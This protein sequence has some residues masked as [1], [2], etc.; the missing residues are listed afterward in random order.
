MVKVSVILPLYNSERF[1]EDCLNSLLN[2][3]FKDYELIILDDCSTD[4]TTEILDK[5]NVKYYKNKKNLGF[6]RNLNK[7]IRM[8][9]GKY[10]M[11]TDHDMIY[12]KNYL[13]DMM[14]EKEDIMAGRCYY[15]S[16]KNLIRG[17]GITIN[18]LT[19]KTTVNGRDKFD[20][21]GNL[22]VYEIAE[23]KSA[24]GGTLMFKKE[25]YD[26]IKF[27]ES[28]NKYY[29][30]IDFCYSA[31]KQGFNMFLSKA[32]CWHKKEKKDVF[33]EQQLKEYYQDKT[34]F[35]KKHSPYYPFCLIP[36]KIKQMIQ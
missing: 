11:I 18:L 23:I 10:I 24:G 32:K 19:G 35:L 8:A 30:D 26:K 9:N 17:L 20:T 25:V 15:Y 29:V 1:V 33:N 7:G 3:T 36:S 6:A 31:R 21:Y 5:K 4:K 28:F 12:D 27:D 22:D 13:S 2:Q 14:S 34:R 16:D